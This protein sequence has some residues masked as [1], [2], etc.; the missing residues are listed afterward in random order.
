[1]DEVIEELPSLDPPL[2]SSRRA[3][4]TLKQ[5]NI[6]GERKPPV[7]TLVAKEI[8]TETTAVSRSCSVKKNPPFRENESA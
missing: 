7:G 5:A 1:M 2:G 4:P 6:G 8:L 3:R